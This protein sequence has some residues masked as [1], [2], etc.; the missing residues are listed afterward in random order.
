MKWLKE[1]LKE[2]LFASEI[3]RLNIMEKS[4]EDTAHRFGLAS[5]QL[6][7]A[8]K[9]VEECRKLVSQLV[10]IGVDVGFHT[11]D[12]SWAVICVAGRPEY[13]KFLPLNGEDTREVINF[14]KRFQD[15][16]RIIDSPIAFRRMIDDKFW[17][18]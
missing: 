5:V 18:K 9:E 12:H 16:H 17:F 14:L 7:N 6:D 15:S 2:W 4:V 8:V 13:V 1:K 11:S 3:Q 10:D